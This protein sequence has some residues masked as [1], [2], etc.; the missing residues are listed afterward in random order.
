MNDARKIEILLEKLVIG[1]KKHPSLDAKFRR[2]FIT[3]IQKHLDD[4]T[5]VSKQ[6]KINTQFFSWFISDMGL[7]KHSDIK[8]EKSLYRNFLRLKRFKLI[9]PKS[10]T[11][12]P[13]SLT[14]LSI[15]PNHF[16]LSAGGLSNLDTFIDAREV[17]LSMLQAKETRKAAAYIY[18]RLFHITP[19]SA[20]TLK[21]LQS[22]TMIRLPNGRVVLLL[23]EVLDFD[24]T[25]ETGMYRLQLLD[26][27]ISQSMKLWQTSSEVESR[28]IFDDENYEKIMQDFK[29]KY[30]TA[31]KIP[32]I[33]NLNKNF[34]LFYSS[35]LELTI[36]AKIV[37]TVPLTLTE[38]EKVFPHEEL[39]SLRQ[40][41]AEKFRIE[42][43]FQRREVLIEERKKQEKIKKRKSKKEEDESASYGM[44]DVESLAFL[45]R[46]KGTQ[47]SKQNVEDAIN[48]IE[49]YLQNTQTLHD[50][51]LFKYV[52]YMLHFLYHR[53]LA[54]STVKNYLGLLNKHLFK[55]VED[56]SNIK[57]HELTAISQRLEVMRYKNSSVKA[58]YKNIRRFFKYHKKRYPELMDIVSL[59]YPKSLVFKHEL[60]DIL[61]EI[62]TAYKKDNNVKSKGETINFHILQRKVLVLFGFYFGLRRTEIR[63]RLKEDFY[64]YDDDFYMDVNSKGLRKVKRKLKTTQS[65]R[66]VHTVIT[67]VNHRKII[68]DWTLLR[69]EMEADKEFL[70]LAKGASNNVLHSAIDEDVLDEITDAIKEV[71]GR[72]CTYHSLRHSFATY[73]I[74]AMLEKGVKTPYALLK[75]SIQMGH[76]TPDTTLAAYVHGEIL[77]LL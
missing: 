45:L 24:V 32:L 8:E 44:M 61:N 63:S 49:D 30:L 64:Q 33:K 57:Q 3:C 7:D 77:E 23:K 9:H 66:R 56:L 73:R 4:I 60:D 42:R 65:K 58:V 14:L 68:D 2:M 34:Y 39:L 48:E 19:L 18:L 53:K 40:K 35:P 46:I 67:D 72:Y 76:Q 47:F 71:T 50:Q 43:V 75:L 6:F 17:L 21:S 20:S 69:N 27:T 36:K 51:I 15:N 28:F 11:F 70:F 37:P 16:S 38:I 55:M 5:I 12:F 62:E 13:K 26:E 25:D 41:D 54:L 29:V 31:L 22:D 1:M 74:K 59:Y 52:L 10:A